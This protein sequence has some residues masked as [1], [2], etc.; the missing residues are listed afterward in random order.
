MS[1]VFESAVVQVNVGSIRKHS[2]EAAQRGKRKDDD[3][4]TG[5]SSTLSEELKMY[6]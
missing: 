6:K 3:E 1:V 5:D 4:Q 2:V